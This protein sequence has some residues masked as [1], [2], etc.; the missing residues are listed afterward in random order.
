MHKYGLK[1]W[2]TNTDWFDAAAQGF[3]ENEFDFIEMAIKSDME[4]K[5][6]PLAHIPLSFHLAMDDDNH[7]IFMPHQLFENT[8]KMRIDDLPNNLCLDIQKAWIAGGMDYVKIAIETKKPFYFHLSGIG[9]KQTHGNL[10]EGYIN[11]VRIKEILPKDC[12]LIFE[13]PKDGSPIDND[14][15]N[16]KYFRQL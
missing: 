5:L 4:N 14:L 1:L 8:A 6:K 10:W 12:Y 3:T 16:M 11:W 15:K 9:E 13:T 7:I 2:S